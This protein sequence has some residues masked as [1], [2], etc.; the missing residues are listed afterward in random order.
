[1][2]SDLREVMVDTL[3]NMN[4]EVDSV[5]DETP[6]GDGGLELESLS[7]AELVMQLDSFGVEFSD[8]EMEKLTSMTFGEFTQEAN[9]RAAGK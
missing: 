3:R 9:R 8:E 1:M 7:L 5:T 6:L 2:S 4:F